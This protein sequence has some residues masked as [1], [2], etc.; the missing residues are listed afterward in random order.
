MSMLAPGIEA[1]EAIDHFVF[2]VVG[3]HD[4]DRQC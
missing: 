1:F 2:I 3:G 4:A